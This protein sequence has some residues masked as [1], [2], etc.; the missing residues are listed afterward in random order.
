MHHL[1]YFYLK[2]LSY[3]PLKQNN[4]LKVTEVANAQYLNSILCLPQYIIPPR[5]T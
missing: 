1:K 4:I 2:S 3:S 5:M